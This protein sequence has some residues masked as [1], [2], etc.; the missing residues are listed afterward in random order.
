MENAVTKHEVRDRKA[1]ITNGNDFDE[2]CKVSIEV[3]VEK[4][5]LIST[6]GKMITGKGVCWV[7]GSS[8]EVDRVI[9]GVLPG[10]DVHANITKNSGGNLENLPITP[11][12]A[13][14][15]HVKCV[16]ESKKTA[17][18]KHVVKVERVKV[19]FEKVV[20]SVEPPLGKV[21]KANRDVTE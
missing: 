17:V 9:Y 4:N 2:T 15:S 14:E 12:E 3:K 5:C 19:N 13:V 8:H 1:T 10:G 21:L 6:T 18:D 7:D 20:K 11:F 16:E